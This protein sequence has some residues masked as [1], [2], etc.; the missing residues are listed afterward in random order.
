MIYRFDTFE[1]DLEK[2]ELRAAGEPRAVEPQV[3][4]LLAF[5][6]ERRDR[7]VSL[8]EILENLWDRRVVSD[9][10]LSSRIKSARKA[11]DDDG[12]AQRYIKTVHRQGLRFMGEVH[13]TQPEPAL[14]SVVATAAEQPPAASTPIAEPARPSIAV[15]PFAIIGDAGPFAAIAEGLPHELIIE[16]AR[17]RWL[18]VIARGS[19]FRLRNQEIDAV[20]AGRLLGVRY[21]LT[22]TVEITGKQLAV[23][24]ELVD[25]RNHHVVWAERYTGFVDEL[26]SVRDEIRSKILASLEIQI[27][28]H[29]ASGARLRDAA[30]LDSWSAYH[31]GLQHLYRF[32]R[33]DNAVADTLFR[34]ALERDPEFARAH[35][36]LSFVHFQTAF[37]RQ[38]DDIAGEIQRARACSQ[39]GIDI[40]P[41]DPFV[42]FTMGRS[43]WLEGDLDRAL[44]WL[45]RS[46]SL[47]PNYA[48]G[49]Y[50]RAWTEIMA[51]LG[52]TAR[53]RVG[54]AMRLSPLDPLYYAMLGVRGLSHMVDG[55]DAEAVE[56][57]E[58]SARA[59]GA[60]VLI[61]MIAAA[62]H[63]IAGDTQRAQAWAEDVRN[64]NPLL[65]REDF[66]RAFPLRPEPMRSRLAAA[67]A[68]LG[69]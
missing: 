45:D 54:L 35:A 47:S 4:A 38:T 27:P 10:A 68:G 13:V 17:L 63:A 55:N 60:H 23:T 2:A 20:D 43:F 28:M 30:S 33:K 31:L 1:L 58:R 56:W 69:F 44:A 62:V 6:I 65:T 39:R 12:Q 19:S 25:A 36:G 52:E 32:N 3:F 50:A 41:L 11:L 7:L 49:V 66:F 34:R 61:S 24:T 21:C 57:C 37:M 67:L 15:L 42:N 40:D 64:R 48:Q 29:E 22:G 26:H 16:L 9:S 51:G 53:E 46:T 59:P 5:L 8:D 14:I 18:F